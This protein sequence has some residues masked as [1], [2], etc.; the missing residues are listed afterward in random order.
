MIKIL[1]SPRPRRGLEL[2]VRTGLADLVLPELPA[3]AREDDEHR[4]HKNVFEHTL[5]VLEQAMDL[6]DPT[7][8]ESPG[9]FDAAPELA[10]SINPQAYKD[11]KLVPGTDRVLA[12]DLVLRLAALLHDIGKPRTRVFH[13][14][15][16]VSFHNHDV[17]GARLARKRLTALKFDSH[18]IDSVCTLVELHLR[19]HGYGEAGWT[20]SAVRRYVRDAGPLLSRLH[21]LTRADCTTRNRRKA[22]ILEHA[23]DDLEHRIVELAA[24][25]TLDSVRP[26]LD[27]HQIMAL[28]DIQPGPQVGKAYQ[29]LLEARLELGPL[30]E[31][32]AEQLLREWWACQPG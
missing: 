15:G 13:P 32:K 27:G 3:L 18:T 7:M 12:P 4:R 28:L 24:Q 26:E 17:V 9:L 30:G 25:E 2:L 20:D 16:T 23:Y 11:T 10:E 22:L 31:H 8:L 1:L 29:F 19:F 5:I 14:D 6:E 21:R